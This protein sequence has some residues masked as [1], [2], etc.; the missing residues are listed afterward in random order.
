MIEVRPA[1]IADADDLAAAH[2]E[3]WRVGYRGLF[4]DSLLDAPEF[5]TS[6]L[7]NWRAWNWERFEGSGH[8]ALVLDGRVVGFSHLG[9]ERVQAGSVGPG[10]PGPVGEV[11]GFYL[12]P[13]AWGSGGATALMARSVE[14]LIDLGHTYAVLWVLRDNPRARAFYEKV[15]WSATGAE[16]AWTGPQTVPHSH[17]PVPEVQY[18]RFL[19]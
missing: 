4:P 8:L 9:P 10:Q 2:I 14:R 5:R 18:G 17:P 3:G 11:Y 12:H 7:A 16:L 6:R 19:K 13:D 1:G 15:G